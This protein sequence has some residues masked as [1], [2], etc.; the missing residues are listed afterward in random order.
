MMEKRRNFPA[1][2]QQRRERNRKK[3]KS[4]GWHVWEKEIDASR[5]G[6]QKKIEPWVG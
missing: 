4:T 6:L 5:Y 2:R 1:E 3:K